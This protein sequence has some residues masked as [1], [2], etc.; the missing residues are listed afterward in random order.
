[1]FESIQIH[2]NIRY[3]QTNDQKKRRVG[4]LPKGRPFLKSGPFKWELPRVWQK[5]CPEVPFLTERG[6]GVKS[7]LGSIF[8]KGFPLWLHS[9]L[10]F[11][12]SS[13]QKRI[14]AN[15]GDCLMRR[16]TRNIAISRL[17]METS[18]ANNDLLLTLFFSLNRTRLSIF[19]NI[20]SDAKAFN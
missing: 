16:L 14:L 5:K 13:F 11:S 9:T 8:K 1:M 3:Y 20:V 12:S 15:F 4:Y 6:R 17:R 19:A 2:N 7:Y 10:P 18:F